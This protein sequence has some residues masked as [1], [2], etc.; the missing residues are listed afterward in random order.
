MKSEE[1]IRVVWEYLVKEDET[2]NFIS[3]YS[4]D[5]E[6]AQLFKKYPGYIKT[7]LKRDTSN[8]QRFITIDHWSSL[9]TYSTMQKKSK[10]DYNLLDEKCQSYTIQ[11]N[12]IGIFRDI[13][14]KKF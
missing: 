9:D 8:R 12:K 2:E 10:A 11:E 13:M 1:T 14:N 7:E 5:G 3:V 6:W 4:S